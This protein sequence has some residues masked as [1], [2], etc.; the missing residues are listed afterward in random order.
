MCT[1]NKKSQEQAKAKEKE[2]GFT[3]AV[4]DALFVTI[5]INQSACASAAGSIYTKSAFWLVPT[6]FVMQNV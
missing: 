4:Q 3:G 2:A 1:D 5:V 6:I